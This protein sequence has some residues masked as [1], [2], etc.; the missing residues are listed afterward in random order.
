MKKKLILTGCGIAATLLLTIICLNLLPD[1]V[2]IVFRG[3]YNYDRY[4]PKVLA[5]IWPVIMSVGGGIHCLKEEEYER[6]GLWIILFAIV[7]L[8]GYLI[9]YTL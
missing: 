2:Y 5:V 9:C 8:T 7:I 3:R 1:R 4:G 6:T